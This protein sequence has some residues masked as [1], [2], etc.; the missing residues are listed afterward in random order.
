MSEIRLP[1]TRIQRFS[2]KDGPGIRTTVFLKGCPLRC[3]WCHNPE[4]QS[5]EPQLLFSRQLCIG[6]GAC[7]AA[8]P[9]GAHQMGQAGHSWQAAACTGCGACAE[10][11]P[12]G[13]CETAAQWMTAEE[14]LRV[15]LQDKP[16]YG[17][18]GGL[19]LSGGEPMLRPAACVSLLQSAKAAG[20]HTAVET[21]GQ[22]DA[23]WLP[24]L[25][26]C[27]DL[28]LWDYKDSDPQR[29]LQYTGAS[30]ERILENLH[31]LDALGAR[32]RLRCIL[33]A[34]V[35][36][37]EQHLQAI[38]QTYTSLRGCEGVDLLPY[39]AYGGSKAVQLG[40]QDTA[41]P[42]WIPT[43]DAVRQAAETLRAAGIPV[44]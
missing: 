3:A 24:E 18:T 27:T 29:H 15:V 39:H 19:T 38:V 17:S 30:N 23:D 40:R 11:C 9:T 13:A 5:P 12:T 22:F 35:N 25:A 44:E 4:T 31:R 16:F 33:V 43:G 1:V 42:D 36:L 28:F 21:C 32:I 2:T 10:A 26:A 14:I 37:N 8:C 41:N 6:C 34:G 20:L 7:T